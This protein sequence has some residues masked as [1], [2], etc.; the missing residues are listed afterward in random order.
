M[1]SIVVT[2]LTLYAFAFSATAQEKRAMKGHHMQKHHHGM[3]M[4]K[5]LNFSEAQKTQAKLYHEDFRKKMQDLNKNESITVKE[6]RDRKAALRKEQRSKMQD[7]LTAEQKTKM[8][9]L[10]ADRK[11]KADEHFAKHLDK[12]KTQLGLTDQQLAQM[13][14]QRESMHSKLKAIK[15]NEALTREQKRDQLVALKTAVKEQHKKILTPE[16]QQKMEDMKK[17]HFE[18]TPAK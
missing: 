18:K 17:K 15:E 5:Q 7:M 12:M 16:Q 4:A 3:M 2:L 9:Q 11:V 8:A 10:K 14:A 6:F 13:K 1:K